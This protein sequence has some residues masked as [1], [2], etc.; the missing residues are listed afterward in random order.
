MNHAEDAEPRCV[1]CEEQHKHDQLHL[2]SNSLSYSPFPLPPWQYAYRGQPQRRLSGRDLTTEMQIEWEKG[3]TEDT[4]YARWQICD[5][6]GM[7]LEETYEFPWL[8]NVIWV[9]MYDLC[10]R[11]W[12]CF[13][14]EEIEYE[15]LPVAA[16]Q[17]RAER[18]EQTIRVKWVFS[19]SV[20]NSLKQKC[21]LVNV[22]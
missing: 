14:N 12:H 16:R 15:C 7:R 4:Q 19:Q 22:S 21:I 8:G 13:T 6:E 9:R 18:E 17:S 11:G 2:P 10:M 5:T 3:S 1:V 20:L